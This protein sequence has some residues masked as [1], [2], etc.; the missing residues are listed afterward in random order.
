MCLYGELVSTLQ[1]SGSLRDLDLLHKFA[2]LRDRVLLIASEG[3]AREFLKGSVGLG[4]Q[5]IGGLALAGRLVV[6]HLWR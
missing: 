6:C 5:L 1:V 3:T 4:E 2:D